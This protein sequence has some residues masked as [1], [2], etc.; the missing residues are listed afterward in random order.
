MIK[1][2]MSIL[3]LMKKE[4][5][6]L[7]NHLDAE[8]IVERTQCRRYALEAIINDIIYLQVHNYVY[9]SCYNCY[10]SRACN[11]TSVGVKTSGSRVGGTELCI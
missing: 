8:K 5:I 9:V 1:K 6:C 10:G 7:V 3:P 11:N 2:L 4:A